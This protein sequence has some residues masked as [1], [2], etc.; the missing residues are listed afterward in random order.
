ML[1]TIEQFRSRV[2]GDCAGLVAD[3][4]TL[5]GRYGSEEAKAW[6]NS[7]GKLSE[8]FQAPS[9]QPLHLYFGR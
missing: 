2:E 5:T 6:E 3:L 1:I 9:F 8:V 7:L 4:Q